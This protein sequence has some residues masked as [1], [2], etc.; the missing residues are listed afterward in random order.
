ML[1]FPH[2]DM[3][4]GKLRPALLLGELPGR[5]GD[6][7]LC[8]ISSQL[9]HAVAGF[10]EVIHDHSDDFSCSGLKSSSVIRLGRLAVASPEI[11]EGS[12]GWISPGRF[13]RLIDRLQAWLEEKKVGEAISK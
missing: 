5:H 10:D 6:V 7:L 9:H 13:S 8:M 3:A 4:Q 2:A 1:R 11:L 12:I